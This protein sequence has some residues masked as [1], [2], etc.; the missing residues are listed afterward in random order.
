[1]TIVIY[2]AEASSHAVFGFK[3][4]MHNILTFILLLSIALDE[5]VV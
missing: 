4:P 3:P 5:Y 2:I 1:M